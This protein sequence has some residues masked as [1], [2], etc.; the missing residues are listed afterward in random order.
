[1]TY[2]QNMLNFP[3][4]HNGKIPLKIPRSGSRAVWLPWFN[5]DFHVQRQA[6]MSGEIF[7]KI[8]SVDFTWSC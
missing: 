3:V 8:R 5:G 2:Q 4:S 6:Y 7:M 1:L